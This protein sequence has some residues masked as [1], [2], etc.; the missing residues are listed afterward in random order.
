MASISLEACPF[1]QQDLDRALSNTHA[2]VTDVA[3]RQHS[4]YLHGYLTQIGAGTLVVESP[5]TDA[6]YLDGFTAYYA[7]CFANFQRSCKRL[8]VFRGSRALDIATKIN[9]GTLSREEPDGLREDYLGFIVARPLPQAII[10]RTALKTFDSDDGRRNIRRSGGIRRTWWV[11]SCSSTAWPFRSRIR[12]SP[13]APPS[14]FGPVSK[15]RRDYSVRQRL[16]RASS[17]E[18]AR[19][20]TT[21]GRTWRCAC[22]TTTRPSCA[23]APP[24][25]PN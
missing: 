19:H 16:L 7:K 22:R 23:T 10:G 20:F 15:R 21:G 12:F 1:T 3:A 8:H 4:N 9:S 25:V 5:Y 6:D 13:R 11:S 17:Q 18:R 2:D 24:Q 14:P